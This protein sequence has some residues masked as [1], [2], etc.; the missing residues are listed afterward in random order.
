MP[1]VKRSESQYLADFLENCCSPSRVSN[2]QLKANMSYY[3][4]LHIGNAFQEMGCITMERKSGDGIGQSEGFVLHIT[5]LGR[6]ALRKLSEANKII[7]ECR[8]QM[9]T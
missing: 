5:S 9:S 3:Q 2:L 6:E 4:V 7:V 8:S 1:K